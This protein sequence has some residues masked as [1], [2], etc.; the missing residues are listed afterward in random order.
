MRE[1]SAEIKGEIDAEVVTTI[2]N[3]GLRFLASALSP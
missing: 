3:L 1:P 2:T